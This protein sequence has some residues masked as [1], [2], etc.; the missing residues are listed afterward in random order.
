MHFFDSSPSQPHTL[1]F[2][3]QK[4]Y[5]LRNWSLL[6][7][8][9]GTGG[10]VDWKV[11]ICNCLTWWPPTFVLPRGNPFSVACSEDSTAPIV[12]IN[13]SFVPCNVPSVYYCLF[14]RGNIDSES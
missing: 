2:G 14:D 5:L 8:T 4:N 6:P 3:L 13:L 10:L 1:T 11:F 12:G 9:L 7:N